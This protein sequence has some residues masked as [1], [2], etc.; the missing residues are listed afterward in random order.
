MYKLCEKHNIP[1]KNLGKW[2]V[3]QNDEDGKTL[4]GIYKN[5]KDLEVSMEWVSQK[6]AK[7]LEPDVS[8]H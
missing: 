6:L 8:H 1:Y 3:G 7:E 5:C 4:E 2:I